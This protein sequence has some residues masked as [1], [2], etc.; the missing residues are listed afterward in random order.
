MQYDPHVACTSRRET[1][2]RR[3]AVGGRG[4]LLRRI[5]WNS[6]ETHTYSLF[7]VGL[8]LLAG[9]A[10]YAIL[11]A[12]MSRYHARRTLSVDGMPVRLD[13]LRGPLRV[14]LPAV[15]LRLAVPLMH[16]PPDAM[17]IA[18]HALWV[19]VIGAAAWL[20]I[21]SVALL[22]T[23]VMARYDMD[24]RDNL[25]A[26]RVY[27]Q[28]RVIERVVDAVLILL[29]IAAMLLTFHAVRRLG[30]SLL[31]SAGVAGIIVGFAAQRSLATLVAGIQIAISQPIR[32]E[33][34]VIVEGE[35]GWIE[36]ITLTYVVVRIW[37][38]RR[39]IV[40]ITYFIEKPFQNWTRTSAQI[41]GTVFIYAD[42]TV[43]VEQLRDELQRILESTPLWDRRA[44][45][46]QVTN[47]TEHTVEL[48][49]LM[50]AEDSSRA[51]DL[52]CLVRE[53]LIA[54]LQATSPRCLPRVR[55]ER[56]P[57]NE[58]DQGPRVPDSGK[59]SPAK[60]L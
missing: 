23:M 34:V 47:A 37:D 24:D 9:L 15:C 22:R 44:W 27:T 16:F 58:G 31:A 42:Y 29:A 14:L 7:I 30:V 45:N 20:G 3:I 49:A 13:L 55:L 28:L 25:K 2:Q 40:P 10:L 43:P 48:R 32:I 19:W 59:F 60:E 33:D 36:E 5:M 12:L 4:L 41:L 21:R 53:R 1:I 35:W 52:R 18:G 6:I 51:W 46:L 57:G 38:Q 56:E 17:A 11:S 39:L 8:T 26:R 54:F 50:S